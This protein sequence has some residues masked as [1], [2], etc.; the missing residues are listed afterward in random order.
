MRQKFFRGQIV[1]IQK[2]MPKSMSH[3]ESGKYAVIQYSYNDQY[4][5]GDVDSF[6]VMFLDDG[7]S[8]SWYKTDQLTLVHDDRVLGET[9]L[10]TLR[11]FS[12]QR[13]EDEDRAIEQ[14]LIDVGCQD[15]CE[16]CNIDCGSINLYKL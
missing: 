7:N 10:Q 12:R 16:R 13:H 14:H 11:E 3:F 4:G 6:S 8:V 9:L 15:D 1:W 5:G 2:E